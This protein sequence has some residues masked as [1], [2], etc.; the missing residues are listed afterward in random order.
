M[1]RTALKLTTSSALRLSPQTQSHIQSALNLHSGVPLNNARFFSKDALKGVGINIAGSPLSPSRRFSV[2]SAHSADGEA[3]SQVRNKEVTWMSQDEI[4]QLIAEG[5]VQFEGCHGTRRVA[6]NAIQKDGF[7]I[8]MDGKYLGT[9]SIAG[10]GVYTVDKAPIAEH[11]A[12]RA[13]LG[14]TDFDFDL[15]MKREIVVLFSRTDAEPRRASIPQ[16][17]LGKPEEIEKFREQNPAD[18]YA[19]EGKTPAPSRFSAA[20][21]EGKTK[22]IS[23][24]GW[25]NAGLIAVK[26][27]PSAPQEGEEFWEK[28]E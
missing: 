16:N 15:D 4:K 27:G 13:S 3:S 25:D 24:D 7:D 19:V 17:I 2:S 22:V 6:A 23:K 1:H 20:G 14:D 26:I 11:Y 10:P 28:K 8:N 5:K 21:I 12:K 18:I 9:K